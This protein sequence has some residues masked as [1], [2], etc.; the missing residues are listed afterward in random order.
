MDKNEMSFNEATLV[1]RRWVILGDDGSKQEVEGEGVI[2]LFPNVTRGSYMEY[3]SCTNMKS[4]GKMGGELR[5]KN[6][7]SGEIYNVSVGDFILDS[8]KCL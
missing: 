5:F 4:H 7:L 3:C 2:G 8:N 1:S 6:N